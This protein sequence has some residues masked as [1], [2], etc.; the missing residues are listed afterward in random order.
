MRF[1][2]DERGRVPFALVGILLLVTSATLSV[3]LTASPEPQVDRSVGDAVERVTAASN[4]AL[5]GVVSR[6]GRRAARAPVTATTNTTFG[7]VVNDSTPF[8]DTLR[9][10]IYLAARD[11]LDEV[12]ARAGTVEASASLPAISNAS[13]LRAAKR[14]V[15][16]ERAGARGESGLRVTIENVTVTA[17]QIGSHDGR[18]SPTGGLV[19]QTTYSPTLTVATPALALHERTERFESRLNHGPLSPGLGRRLTASLYPVAWARGYAHYGKAPIEN[20]VANRHVSLAT[21][22]AILREQRLAFGQADPSG[23]RA[24][25]WATARVGTTDL[26]EATHAD[27]ASRWTNLLLAAA[28]KETEPAP[29]DEKPGETAPVSDPLRVGVNRTADRAYLGLVGGSNLSAVLEDAYGAEVRLRAAIRAEEIESK[30]TP[31]PPGENWTK[32]SEQ[33]R[34]TVRVT[35]ASGPVPNTLS[36]WHRQR[37]ATRRV[38]QQH[39]LVVRWR[40]DGT[41]TNATETRRTVHRWT[42]TYRVGLVLAGNHSSVE[43]APNRP[44]EGVHHRGGP[45]DGPNLR[46]VPATASERLVKGRGGFDRL[47]E[48]AVSGTLDTRRATISGRRPAELRPWVVRDLR[49]LREQVR[50]VT[51]AVAREEV[52]TGDGNPAALLAQSLR[53]RRAELLDAPASYDG[54]AERARTA[55]RAA[56]LDGVLQRL[57]AR[58]NRTERLNRGVDDVLSDAGL[59]AERIQRIVEVKAGVEPPTPEPMA[60]SGPGQSVNLSVE[61]A[62]P[63]L[64]LSPIDH[65]QVAAIPTGDRNYPLAARNVNLFTVPYADAADTATG[66]LDGTGSNQ[67]ADLQSAA[68]SLRAANRT[69]AEKSNETLSENR[70]A[71]QNSLSGSLRA[72]QRRLAARLAARDD[73]RSAAAYRTVVRAG[74]ARWNTTTARTL[75]VTNGSVAD[76]IADEAVRRDAISE[77][78]IRAER[79]RLR[80][81]FALEATRKH[82][83]GPPQSL[84]GKT[85]AKA[86]WVAREEV[87]RVLG[88]SVANATQRSADRVKDRWFGKVLSDVHAGLPVAPVP[89]YW[90]ATANV[91]H[92]E[93]RGGYAEFSVHAPQGS[94]L[95]GRSTGGVVTYTRKSGRVRLDVDGDGKR[96]LIGRT[97][98]VSFE[99]STVVVVVVPPGPPGVGDTDGDADERSP[100]WSSK[101]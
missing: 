61:G 65:E 14:R 78:S 6:A 67:R 47:A 43:N 38:V 80:V 31:R 62:P 49:S 26:V 34:T 79:L 10:R 94:P 37:S 77:P 28:K 27:R 3:T 8:R 2:E 72:I 35:N 36:G 84:V 24:L 5:R 92:V 9:I 89:G 50:N 100:G 70:D 45:L 12:S 90:Y 25:G 97:T 86:R 95:L 55:A 32:T 20:V 69:L 52:A 18:R 46:D 42:E 73:Q 48:R 81:R 68:L 96:E 54:V 58:A 29:P 101:R 74:L 98:P 99:T 39:S 53:D 82:V 7:A 60:A 19:E 93:V 44:V 64:T 13:A 56:Y 21:N 33:V 1:A 76:V 71:L 22:G 17:R 23:R 30:P 88:D 11:S 87:K 51:V 40:R 41:G 4:T 59:S 63:Y 85:S 75:A 66:L 91:W 16:I 83:D 15:R 57:K